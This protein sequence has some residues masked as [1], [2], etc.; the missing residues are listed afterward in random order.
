V[1]AVEH[2]ISFD[3]EDNANFAYDSDFAGH[4][5]IHEVNSFA[6]FW[7]WMSSGL[8]PLL[9]VQEKPWSEDISFRNS[10]SWKWSEDGKDEVE[11]VGSGIEPG[12]TPKVHLD[13]QQWGLMIYYNRVVGGIRLRQERNVVVPCVPNPELDAFYNADC[14]G[15]V[16]DYSLDPDIDV[17]R[18]MSP[19]EEWTKWLWVHEEAE[20]V[21]EKVKQLELTGWLDKNTEKIEISIPIYNAEYSVHSLINVNFFFTRGGHVWKHIIAQSIYANWFTSWYQFGVDGTYFGCISWI[22][23]TEIAEVAQTFHQ[24]GFKGIWNDYVNIWNMVD[25]MAITFGFVLMCFFFWCTEMSNALNAEGEKIGKIPRPIPHLTPDLPD[26]KSY[27]EEMQIGVNWVTFTQ[28]WLARYPLVIVFRLFKSFHAQPRLALVTMT[29]Q[30]SFDDLFHF[31]IVFF[32]VM[33]GFVTSAVVL[34]GREVDELVTFNRASIYCVRLI[35]GDMDFDALKVAGRLLAGSWMMV[36]MV[37]GSLLLL[38]MLLAIVM[39][40]YSDVKAGSGGSQTLWGQIRLQI[41]NMDGMH[42]PLKIIHKAL[43]SDLPDELK[44]M[45]EKKKLLAKKKKLA[46][47]AGEE[48]DE[49][50]EGVDEEDEYYE[51]QMQEWN[52]GLLKMEHLKEVV[53]NPAGSKR[54]NKDGNKDEDVG[55]MVFGKSSKK[56]TWTMSDTQAK[57][58]LIGTILD[59]Y[60][61]NQESADNFEFIS[62]AEK[63]DT[64]L[65]LTVGL[66]KRFNLRED[67]KPQLEEADGDIDDDDDDEKD[68]EAEDSLFKEG[69]DVIDGEDEKMRTGFDIAQVMKPSRSA[70]TSKKDP[71]APQQDVR[72]LMGEVHDEFFKFLDDAHADRRKSVRE[73][74]RLNVEVQALRDRLSE[75]GAPG[76]LL[77][78]VVLADTFLTRPSQRQST[79]FGPGRMSPSGSGSGSARSSVSETPGQS[80]PSM[81]G[82]KRPSA[83]DRTRLSRLDEERTS[84]AESDENDG[85]SM[86]TSVDGPNAPQSSSLNLATNRASA[87]MAF[88]DRAPKSIS[89]KT[90]SRADLAKGLAAGSGRKTTLNA[91]RLATLQRK[92]SPKSGPSLAYLTLMKRQGLLPNDYASP[93]QGSDGGWQ[94]DMSMHSTPPG[95]TVGAQPG[96]RA[97]R[98]SG[99]GA[100]SVSGGDAGERLSDFDENE[101]LDGFSDVFDLGSQQSDDDMGDA[102]IGVAFR[103]H[104]ARLE[105]GVGLTGGSPEFSGEQ[106]QDFEFT[107]FR[108]AQSQLRFMLSKHRPAGEGLGLHVERRCEI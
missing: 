62:S 15:N 33:L 22:F 86:A 11:V 96:S 81:A 79:T 35:L 92:T 64:R 34:F 16:K 56:K 107:T 98:A 51:S 105:E 93:D 18:S 30:S 82:A 1:R 106:Q 12:L 80:R 48:P 19:D 45:Q 40:A 38:N 100:G 23:L 83:R 101:F 88:T 104:T 8:V 7:S 36:F 20:T 58:I 52:L 9:W 74:A 102:P 77:P 85:A 3:V 69:E 43:A 70:V 47:E 97:Q 95:S 41:K 32:S 14:K 4:K 71:K 2:S 99:S 67:A 60:D 24:G 49:D 6:D 61:D 108:D 57:E 90:A 63:I 44:K 25:W 46:K 28:K 75:T 103:M 21:E 27:I 68:M 17:A 13:Q 73:I 10:T 66:H 78:S 26:V 55:S 42:V 29:L 53:A 54:N 89:D 31:L 91:E 5:D 87:G 72:E 50:E 37:F 76:S 39:D 59:Y 94:D 84:Q 65:N